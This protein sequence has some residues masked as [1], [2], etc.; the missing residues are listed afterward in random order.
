M[1]NARADEAA[2]SVLAIFGA[3]AFGMPTTLLG[4]V[5]RPGRSS[6]EWHYWWQAHFVDCLVDALSR[7]SHVVAQRDVGRVMRG[8]WLRN[9]LRFTNDYFDDMAWLALATQR[10]GCAPH[11]LRGVLQSALE[12]SW[13]GALWST[14]R[15][16]VNTAATA[17]IALYL[18]RCGE[19]ATPR[20][21]L[22]WLRENLADEDGLLRDGL[23]IVDG[24]LEL[25]GHVF[26]Y[27]QGPV[28]GLMLELGGEE[29]AAAERHVAAIGKRLSLPGSN[30]LVTHGG[31]DGGL[32]TGILTRYL[33]LA[34]TDAR[35]APETRGLAA[36][37]V[38]ATADDL[39]G[40]RVERG[41]RH[42][43]VTVFPAGTGQGTAPESVELSTQLQ[44]WMTLESAA[45]VT[46]G[47]R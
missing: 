19:Q 38:L 2:R 20:R 4:A 22:C 16:F 27:N 23:R 9:G 28:L 31:G 26:T 32:F 10:V 18:A 6:G 43:P 30:V 13:G 33:A 35:L 3:R 8:M 11:R 12:H 39:W 15:D 44:A 14:S 21:L 24:R 25:V 1:S 7:G 37:L 45:T 42:R 36:D 46:A 41:W 40:R 29:L 34:V 5:V 47:L 17:P